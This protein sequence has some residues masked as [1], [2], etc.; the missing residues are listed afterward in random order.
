M[1]VALTT[2]DR[3]IQRRSATGATTATVGGLD[4][5][6]ESNLRQPEGPHHRGCDRRIDTRQKFAAG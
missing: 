3:R 1:A 2:M 4:R 5:L 6:P